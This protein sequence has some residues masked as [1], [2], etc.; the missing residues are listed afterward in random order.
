[1]LCFI[2]YI[3][4]IYSILLYHFVYIILFYVCVQKAGPCELSISWTYWDDVTHKAPTADELRPGDHRRHPRL[5]RFGLL[6][7]VLR[8]SRGRW[9]RWCAACGRCRWQ[10]RDP[11]GLG[12]GP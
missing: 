8:A 5:G 2:S 3:I 4:T 7:L 10:S 9:W 1:M 6:P 11:G 12:E